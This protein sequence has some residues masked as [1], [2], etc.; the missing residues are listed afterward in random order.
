MHFVSAPQ[1]QAQ[2]R[3]S[4]SDI[5]KH[6]PTVPPA[7]SDTLLPLLGTRLAADESKAAID[8]ASALCDAEGTRSRWQRGSV[9]A[10][11]PAL[12]SP[13]SSDGMAFDSCTATGAQKVHHQQL[14]ACSGARSRATSKRPCCGSGYGSCLETAC[15]LWSP[16]RS[17]RACSSLRLV[18]IRRSR[19]I[20]SKVRRAQLKEL[21]RSDASAALVACAYLSCRSS[22]TP[23]W[24]PASRD[25]RRSRVCGAA[26]LCTGARELEFDRRPRPLS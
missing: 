14:V 25:A 26:V 12:A 16:P 4:H 3:R 2:V 19:W 7:R 11:S 6:T 10:I 24:H 1:D 13:R 20:F 15:Q 18:A 8:S 17:C 5:P 22:V 23:P 9:Q 21:E